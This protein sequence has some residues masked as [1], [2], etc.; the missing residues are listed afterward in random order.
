MGD[1]ANALWPQDLCFVVVLFMQHD[2]A[3]FSHL[4]G[5]FA[6]TCLL[7]HAL[8]P[9]CLL[10]YV[11]MHCLWCW[12]VHMFFEQTTQVD[13]AGTAIICMVGCAS[14]IDQHRRYRPAMTS[15]N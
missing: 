13:Q 4:V 6:A 15:I 11:L 10:C 5:C 8:P 7:W 14:V 3:C 12:G 9:F 2:R 1:F